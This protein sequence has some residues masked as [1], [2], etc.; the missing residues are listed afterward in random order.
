MIK[1]V[2]TRNDA[3]AT[4][5]HR[6][7]FGKRESLRGCSDEGQFEPTKRLKGSKRHWAIQGAGE[8]IGY[9][10][11]CWGFLSFYLNSS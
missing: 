9:G 5:G 11:D 2:V 7:P 3:S 1:S 4:S 8:E 6:E 10:T